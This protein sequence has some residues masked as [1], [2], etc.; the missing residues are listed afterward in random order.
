M[1]VSVSVRASL[2][3]LEVLFHKCERGSR[4]DLKREGA[5]FGVDAYGLDLK[6]SLSGRTSSAAANGRHMVDPVRA[7][8][9][10]PTQP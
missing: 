3:S 1:C 6:K 4:P 10:E 2:G 9:R 7:H 5:Y 8:V